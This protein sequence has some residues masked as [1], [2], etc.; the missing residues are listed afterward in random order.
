VIPVMSGTGPEASRAGFKRSAPPF[1]PDQSWVASFD[2]DASVEPSGSAVHDGQDASPPTPAE[3][4]SWTADFSLMTDSPTTQA[5]GSPAFDA[6]GPPAPAKSEP[7][8]TPDFPP[9]E[10]FATDWPV[11]SPLFTNLPTPTSTTNKGDGGNA[12]P[13]ATASSDVGTENLFALLGQNEPPAGQ[14]Q[15]GVPCSAEPVSSNGSPNDGLS[16]LAD[17]D[18]LFPSSRGL[19]EHSSSHGA[20]SPDG[21][22]EEQA[23]TVNASASRRAADS[24]DLTT[25]EL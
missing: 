11:P 16:C 13:P 14:S 19:G 8:W 15:P 24:T 25:L 3:G 20:A 1:D 17:F 10:S 21:L 18:P 2:S 6:S 12:S 23:G 5:A 7:Q 4:P 9:A 22:P